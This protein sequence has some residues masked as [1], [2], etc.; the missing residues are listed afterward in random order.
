VVNSAWTILARLLSMVSGGVLAI[1]AIRT[2][3][4]EAWGDYSTV[5]SLMA[6]F[7]VFTEMGISSLTVRDMSSRPG[8]DG[9]LLA[10]ALT[11]V[12]VTGTVS[13]CLLFLTALVLQFDFDYGLLLL[14]A[15]VLAVQGLSVPIYA[16]FTARRVLVYGAVANVGSAV[17]TAATGIALIALGWGPAGLLTGILAGHVVRWALSYSLVRSR[18][19]LTPRLLRD[20]WGRVRGFL[21]AAVPIAL[22]GGLTIV[23][24]RLDILMLSKLSD[25]RE[26]ALYSVPFTILQYSWIVPAAV[27]G[28]Y[29]PLLTAQLRT[30][31]EVARNSFLLLMRF[32]LLMSVPFTLLLVVGGEPLLTFVF[33]DRYGE[34]ADVLSVLAWISVL[35]FQNYV[36]WYGILACH[37]EKDVVGIQAAGLVLNA[38]LNVVFIPRWGGMGAAVALVISDFIVVAGQALVVHRHLFPLPLGSL[39]IRPLI[40]GAV[41]APVVL[42]LVD[43]SEVL[44]AVSAAVVYGGVLIALRYIKP[45]EWQPLWQPVLGAV[46]RLRKKPHPVG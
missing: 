9:Q 22:T 13:I 43:V 18:L 6:I 27:A 45:H 31:R 37:R 38:A 19:S 7:A 10:L 12:V 20:Q 29:F 3:S 23:Y 42:L 26:V 15:A 40:A 34:S 21:R 1:Y 5:I 24:Q 2:L 46:R 11:A 32:F 33:G 17:A 44:A 39:L 14:T 41:T 4:V 36:L 30:D 16:T 35:G 28:A 8:Q 25:A